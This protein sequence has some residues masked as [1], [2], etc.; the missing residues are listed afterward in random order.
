MDGR[1]AIDVLLDFLGLFFLPR[2]LHEAWHDGVHRGSRAFKLLHEVLC[3]CM[4]GRLRDTVGQHGG[5]RVEAHLRAREEDARPGR[6]DGEELAHH[7]VVGVDGHLHHLVPVLVARLGERLADGHAGIT[8]QAVEVGGLTLYIVDEPVHIST[9]RL[10]GVDGFEVWNLLCELRSH[11]G[12]KDVVA[13]AE[14]HLRHAQPDAG[15]ATCY[16]CV[17]HLLIICFFS[18]DKYGFNLFYLLRSNMILLHHP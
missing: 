9:R 8:H 13:L 6:D 3:Q 7:D 11:V 4:D 5:V 14:K 16:Y 12:G 17:F 15:C 10:V 2:S 18:D 1:L